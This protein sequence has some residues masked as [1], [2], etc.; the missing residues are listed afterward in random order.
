M[1]PFIAFVKDES[2]AQAASAV[3]SNHGWSESCV[4]Y[5]DVRQ[6]IVYL[7]E[8][9]CPQTLLI[10]IPDAEQAP[11]LLDKLAD[12]CTPGMQVIVAGKVNEFSFYNWLKSIG[13]EYYLL[14]PFEK[15]ALEEVLTKPKQD[16]HSEADQA[17]GEVI[18]LIGARGGVGTT[19]VASNLA[20]L[21]AQSYDQNTALIDLDPYFGSAAMAFDI[22]PGH[23]LRDALEKPDRIDEMF[24]DR[25]MVKY[26]DQLSILAAEEAFRETLSNSADSA[27]ALMKQLRAHYEK[28]VIDLPRAATPL[29]R[30][31]L[32]QADR[33]IVVCELSLL[34]LRDVLRFRDY[35]L[36]ELQTTEPLIVA[37]R[38]G[39]A[40][41]HELQK[42]SFEKH[43]GRSIDIHL[44]CMMEAFA[45]TS[46][47][48][49]LVETT[50]NT[51]ALDALHQLAREFLSDEAI[52]E[53]EDK[54]QNILTK[55][56]GGF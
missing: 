39:L 8:K 14:Q 53:A 56:M 4:H 11:D 40:T 51:D 10:E 29:T 25:V 55:L 24:L 23:G 42:T 38:E 21:F 18:A 19:T 3:A 49:I 17:T 32:A 9:P 12:Y 22:E 45:S 7:Q 47:G 54:P 44:P 2:S 27:E 36:Q 15:S 43:Y 50:K 6:A 41:K 26:Q 48:N 1:R 33:V 28:V 34:S 30:S 5:G 13:I 31:I 20:Y 52:P 16:K 35:L 46:E 37:N